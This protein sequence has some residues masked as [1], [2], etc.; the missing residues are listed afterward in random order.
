M[1]DHQIYIFVL[2]DY[3]VNLK[4]RRRVIGSTSAVYRLHGC[5]HQELK[6]VYNGQALTAIFFFNKLRENVFDEGE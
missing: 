4:H 1:L 5:W 2:H 3:E 6:G